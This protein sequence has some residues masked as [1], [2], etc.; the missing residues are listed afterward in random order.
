LSRAGLLAFSAGIRE[1][2]LLL[3][4]KAQKTY[5]VLTWMNIC[6]FG[7]GLALFAVAAISG[8]VR[9][10]VQMPIVFGSLGAT[11]FIIM[12][13]MS[14]LKKSQQAL[15]NLAQ[16]NIAVLTF[17]EQ[18]LWWESYVANH[19]DE[20]EKVSQLSYER[21]LSIVELL[22]RYVENDPDMAHAPA[23]APAPAA[24]GLRR[25]ENGGQNLPPNETRPE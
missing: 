22:Q 2:L 5:E 8:L 7:F 1:P 10:E 24:H 23:P 15:S 3:L 17:V 20:T 19:Q 4:K 12:F 13:V 18:M 25:R 14:P 6:L 9:R 16:V 21:A 11:N